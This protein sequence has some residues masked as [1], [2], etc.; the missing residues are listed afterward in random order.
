MR[1]H[2]TQPVL[3]LTDKVISLG[4]VSFSL[5]KIGMKLGIK[6]VT[7]KKLVSYKAK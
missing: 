7:F 2:W 6:L 1:R 4:F 5:F 3:Y